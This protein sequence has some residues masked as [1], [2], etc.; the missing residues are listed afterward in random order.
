MLEEE[1][2]KYESRRNAISAMWKR[3]CYGLEMHQLS[4]V[5]TMVVVD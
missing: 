1:L 3:F 2:I 4:C 5:G